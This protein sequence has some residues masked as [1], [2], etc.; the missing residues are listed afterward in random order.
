MTNVER[1]RY[2]GGFDV[3]GRA[4]SVGGG[5]SVGNK[6]CSDATTLVGGSG[7]KDM[8]DFFGRGEGRVNQKVLGENRTLDGVG[9]VE[10]RVKKVRSSNYF[11]V[12]V[13]RRCRGKA[14]KKN[15]RC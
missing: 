5:E 14:N 2:R 1:E 15:R 12:S 4:G 11:C 9:E 7:G 8:E 10:S 6:H 3:C 13:K